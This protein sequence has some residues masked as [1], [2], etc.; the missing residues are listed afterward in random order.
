VS[1]IVLRK[2]IKRIFKIWRKTSNLAYADSWFKI[3][4]LITPIIKLIILILIK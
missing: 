3:C 4:P 1:Y 2:I